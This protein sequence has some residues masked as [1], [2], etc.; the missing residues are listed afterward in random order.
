[1]LGPA[2]LLETLE[3]EMPSRGSRS[4]YTKAGQRNALAIA[5]VSVAGVFDPT[6]GRVRLALGS[7]APTPVRA[8]SA[9]RFFAEGWSAATDRDAFLCEVADRA[10]EATSCID[11]VRATATHRRRLIRV[12]VERTL[13]RLCAG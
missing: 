2:D 10:V 11:D 8:E 3:F 1:M 6:E 9:E 5:I 12:L 4:A 13:T 7:V